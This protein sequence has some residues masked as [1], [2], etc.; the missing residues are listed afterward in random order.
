MDDL[1]EVRAGLS[2]HVHDH[3]A[4]LAVPAGELV[5]LDAVDD[6]GD[7]AEADRGA[8]MLANSCMAAYI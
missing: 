5:V 8:G 2:L 1:D 4:L 7:I 3:R 6:G